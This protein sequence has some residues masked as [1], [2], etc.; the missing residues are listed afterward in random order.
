M[1]YILIPPKPT[2]LDAAGNPLVNGFLTTFSAGT[3][4]KKATFADSSLTQENPNPIRLNAR[5]EPPNAVFTD[6]DAT[7]KLVL[8]NASGQVQYTLDNYRSPARPRFTVGPYYRD[9]IAADLAATEMTSLQR[10][11]APRAGNITGLV[12]VSSLA[13]TAGSLTVEVFKNTGLSGAV[14]SATGLIA[15]LDAAYTQR[16]AVQQSAVLDAFAEGDEL[17]CVV[18]SDASWAPTTADLRAFIEVAA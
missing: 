16:R 10:W 1:P 3:T 17:Y 14:G 15:T 5:G 9:N 4:T 18:T 11:V 7:Y 12:I 2:F 8:S 13:R 6:D